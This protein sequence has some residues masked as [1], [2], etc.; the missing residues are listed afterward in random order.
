MEIKELEK[1]HKALA[2]KRRL[3][4]AQY[5]RNRK[6]ANLG[7]IAE[8]LRL[9]YKATSRHL[10]VLVAADILEKEQR[11]SQMFFKISKTIPTLAGHTLDIL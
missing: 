5:L 9:S 4:V 3:A 10:A 11:S 7:T 6:E 2:N 8:H 1:I